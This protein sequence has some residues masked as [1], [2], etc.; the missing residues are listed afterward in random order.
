MKQTLEG[1]TL[2]SFTVLLS[3]L[4]FLGLLGLEPTHTPQQQQTVATNQQ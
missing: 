4:T 3:S 1:L 2:F